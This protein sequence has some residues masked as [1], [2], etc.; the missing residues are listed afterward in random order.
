MGELSDDVDDSSTMMSL[1]G[2]RPL[3]MLGDVPPAASGGARRRKEI[4]PA[5]ALRH[6]PH[7]ATTSALDAPQIGV[8]APRRAA[9]ALLW[10]ER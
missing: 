9:R 1:L 3:A 6:P 4:A 2:H 7:H 5:G 10:S 8:R